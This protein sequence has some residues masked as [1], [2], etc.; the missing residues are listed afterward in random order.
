[1]YNPE[2]GTLSVIVTKDHTE[3]IEITSLGQLCKAQAQIKL[4]IGSARCILASQ[5]ACQIVLF[6]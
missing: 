2:E 5:F 3:N 4:E 6:E 1:M